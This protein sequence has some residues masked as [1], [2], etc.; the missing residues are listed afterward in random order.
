MTDNELHDRLIGFAKYQSGTTE[1]RSLCLALVRY[2]WAEFRLL[3]EA[4]EPAFPNKPSLLYPSKF[5]MIEN[6]DSRKPGVV[7]SLCGSRQQHTDDVLNL[8][9]QGN[10][11]KSCI[12]IRVQSHADLPAAFNGLTRAFQL[13]MEKSRAQELRRN[14]QSFQLQGIFA[15]AV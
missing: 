4:T 1:S 15:E 6:V 13:K 11:R 12:K 3:P 10:A 2:I 14:G 5:A 8:H 7:V 9:T